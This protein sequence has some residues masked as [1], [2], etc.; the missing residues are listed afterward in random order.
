MKIIRISELISQWREFDGR[1]NNCATE[2]WEMIYPFEDFKPKTLREKFVVWLL[3]HIKI[4]KNDKIYI[5]EN[6][7]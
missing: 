7:F 5:V 2:K 4:G 1:Y 3:G 6:R